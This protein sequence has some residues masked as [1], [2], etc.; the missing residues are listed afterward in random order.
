MKEIIIFQTL[1]FMLSLF[2]LPGYLSGQQVFI[3]NEGTLKFKS[4]APL[5]LIQAAS[6]EM[7]G[8][9]SPSERTFA[10]SV[11]MASFQGFNSPLQRE[12]FNENYMESNKFPDA[13]FTGRI[14]EEVDLRQPGEYTIRTKGMLT[15]HGISQERIIKTNVLVEGTKCTI[16]GTFTVLLADHAITIPK[17]VHQKIAEEIEV[18][19]A[20]TLRIKSN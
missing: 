9:I 8:A 10:F 14:I 1:S 4:D 3:T 17:V 6:T 20:A 13:T 11:P 2:V 19:V 18:E 5:E 12:H 7:R 15:I 16:S